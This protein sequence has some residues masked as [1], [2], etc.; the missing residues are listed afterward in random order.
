MNGINCA[1]GLGHFCHTGS[2]L[3]LGYMAHQADG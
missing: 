3:M 2:H 1:F